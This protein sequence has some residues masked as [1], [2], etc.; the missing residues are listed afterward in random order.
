MILI[1]DGLDGYGGLELATQRCVNAGVV[2]HSISVTEAADRRLIDIATQTGG[3]VFFFSEL[4][5]TSLAAMLSEVITSGATIDA[6]AP[7]TVN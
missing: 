4:G 7:V 6:L 2:V 5:V 1:S 3:K